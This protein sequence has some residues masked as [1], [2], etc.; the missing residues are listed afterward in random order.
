MEN[1]IRSVAFRRKNYLF[2]GSHSGAKRAALV[3]SLL[4][5]CKLQN[6]NPYEYLKDVLERL[7]AHPVN[8]LVNL[9]PHRWKPLSKEA[10]D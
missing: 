8:Q 4:I 2:A 5:S 10:A 3:Y 7:P 1:A 6:V 9:L